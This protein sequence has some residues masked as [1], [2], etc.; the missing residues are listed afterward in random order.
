[1]SLSTLPTELFHV[2]VEAV[3][4]DRRGRVTIPGL[5]ADARNRRVNRAFRAASQ[6][7]R[8]PGFDALVQGV[9]IGGE[10]VPTCITNNA[11]APYATGGVYYR[12]LKMPY[13]GLLIARQPTTGRVHALVVNDA[14]GEVGDGVEK[15]AYCLPYLRLYSATE[16]EPPKPPASHVAYPHWS[17]GRNRL[18]VYAINLK[19]LVLNLCG[20]NADYENNLHLFDAL[21]QS[22]MRDPGGRT[23]TRRSIHVDSS[24]FHGSAG[25][26]QA[27]GAVCSRFAAAVGNDQRHYPTIWTPTECEVKFQLQASRQAT[28]ARTLLTPEVCMQLPPAG[29]VLNHGNPG[30]A[31]LGRHQHEPAPNPDSIESAVPSLSAMCGYFDEPAHAECCGWYTHIDSHGLPPAALKELIG[32]PKRNDAEAYRRALARVALD[33]AEQKRAAQTALVVHTGVAG[34]ALARPREAATAAG[35]R[36]GATIADE[37]DTYSTGE[38]KRKHQERDEPEAVQAADAQY[39]ADNEPE[40]PMYDSD[41]EYVED[42]RRSRA[43]KLAE[44]RAEAC[45]EMKALEEARKQPSD[46]E[47]D[48]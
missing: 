35:F 23:H 29:G 6:D 48:I 1:M 9:W 17:V 27:V 39:A 34:A 3:R 10:R 32:L 13:A 20:N 40:D 19:E 37:N 8:A 26:R 28:A 44:R 25:V 12:D 41:A 7:V 45:A 30:R 15:K 11:G 38:L 31:T 43:Q 47:D 5:V 22:P 46:D 16:N 33:R 2:V 18:V 24:T 36:L 21:V 4:R 42:D 14:R